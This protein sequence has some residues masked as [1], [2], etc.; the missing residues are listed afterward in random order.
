MHERIQ[1]GQ[2]QPYLFSDQIDRP[3]KDGANKKCHYKDGKF[4]LDAYKNEV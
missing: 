3:S 4:D 1:C 2:N